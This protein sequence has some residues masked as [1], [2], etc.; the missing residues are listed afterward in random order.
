MKVKTEPTNI[1]LKLSE[2][3]EDDNARRE[4]DNG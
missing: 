3:H 2:I 4:E 1:P